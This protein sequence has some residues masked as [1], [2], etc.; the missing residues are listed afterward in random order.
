MFFYIGVC[1]PFKVLDVYYSRPCMSCM[2]SGSQLGRKF[3]SIAL[4]LAQFVTVGAL[5]Y[6]ELKLRECKV[7]RL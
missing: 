3:C 2:W 5:L 6:T 7:L 4:S 1:Y